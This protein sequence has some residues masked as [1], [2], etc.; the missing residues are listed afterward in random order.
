MPIEP[1]AA[2]E[3]IK[4]TYLVEQKDSACL[5]GGTRTR[6]VFIFFR[7]WP[8]DGA[9]YAIQIRFRIERWSCDATE[10]VQSEAILERVPF[11]PTDNETD[12]A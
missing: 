9:P 2:A 7:R 3:I 4:F 8:V 11:A 10:R 1:Q 12:T 5:N 6:I